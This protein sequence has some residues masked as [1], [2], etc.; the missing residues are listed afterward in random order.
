MYSVI[1]PSA[2]HS[3]VAPQL[4]HVAKTVQLTLIH[5]VLS[6]EL[7]MNIVRAPKPHKGAQKRKTAL[8]HLKSQFALRKS[9][10]KFLCVKTVSDK[11]VRHSLAYLSVFAVHK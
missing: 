1:K 6:N 2:T 4:Q 8:F 3:L 5:H 11:V 7:N 9:A 10:I